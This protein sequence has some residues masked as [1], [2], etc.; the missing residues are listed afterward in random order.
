MKKFFLLAFSFFCAAIYSAP[1]QSAALGSITGQIVNGT[2]DASASSAANLTVTLYTALANATTPITTT[3][4][5]DVS[6]KFVFTNLDTLAD[7]RYLLTTTYA[8]VD[9]F[10]DLLSFAANQTS[11]NSSLTIRET[12]T[13]P[14]AIRVQQTHFIFNVGTRVF[15]VAQ[16]IVL[17]N[18]SDRTYIGAPLAGPHRATLTLPILAGARNI[19]FER[20]DANA[21]T[22]PTENGLTYTLPIYPGAEQIVYTSEVPFTP[23]TYQFDL[24]MPFASA[25]FRILL[26]DVGGTIDSAQ[27]AKPSPFAAQNGQK[28]WLTSAPNVSSGTMIHATFTNLPASVEDSSARALDLNAPL[29]SGIVMSVA[30]IGMLALLVLPFTRRARAPRR[31]ELLQTLA[32]LDDAFAA[33]EIAADDYRATRARVKAELIELAR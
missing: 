22:L 23:P 16:I 2:K 30:A 32:D 15:N 7:T 12:T 4:R 6:G 3:A 17:Q 24:K 14:S 10:S 1:A 19:Q 27:L 21:T 11:L 25:Q 9:Y 5:S 29:V 18:A 33:R 8:D 28:F 13:D 20:D 31:D 26:Q